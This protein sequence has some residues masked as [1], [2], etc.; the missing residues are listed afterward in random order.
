MRRLLGLPAPID[1]A[2]LTWL[3]DTQR[4]QGLVANATTV[5]WKD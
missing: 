1:P 2:R 3:E 5:V 4:K